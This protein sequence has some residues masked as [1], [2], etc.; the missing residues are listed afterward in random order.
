MS[1]DQRP[2]TTHPPEAVLAVGA[3]GAVT[4]GAFYHHALQLAETLPRGKFVVN[5]CQDRY[6]F[7]LGLAAALLRGQPTLMP[8]S[9]TPGTMKQIQAHYT[10]IVN[11]HDGQQRAAGLAEYLIADDLF[12]PPASAVATPLIDADQVAAI[13]FTSGSTGEPTA[14]AKRWGRLC[15]NG[16]SE[17]ER[18]QCAHHTIV[19]TVPAQH[20]YGFESSVLLAMHG[21][22]SVWR[23][24]PF[25][26]ADVAWALS[27]APRPRMLVTTPFHLSNIVA[28]GGQMPP[29]GIV[30]CA[31]AP[32]SVNLAGA[33]EALFDSPLLE[34]Y[35]CTESGQIA[36]RRTTAGPT[37]QLLPGLAMALDGASTT[38]SVSGGHVE[39]RVYLTDHITD[40]DGVHFRLGDRHTDMVNI[41]GK[42]ASLAALSATLRGLPD[43]QDGCFLLPQAVP[44]AP[45]EAIQRLAALVVAPSLS[46]ASLQA[47]LRNSIDAAFLPRPLLKVS[48]LPRNATGKLLANEVQALFQR[49][50]TSGDSSK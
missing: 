12:A 10:D 20:M 30:L 25:Y 49:A 39:G 47:L 28:S 48:A 22:C 44:G 32:L 50:R 26:P 23:D 45:T 43:V 38:V 41:A 36:S 18:L 33:A 37:W 16:A 34:I 42:R 35:G 40:I 6:L 29:C 13:V 7:M 8:S 3:R 4:V 19:A 1:R 21:G 15:T 5:T 31:T 2:L 11:L 46:E 24:R 17:A 27:A 9:F 14:H